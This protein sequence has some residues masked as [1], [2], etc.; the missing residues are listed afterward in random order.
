MPPKKV[1]SP[2]PVMNKALAGK[3]KNPKPN[4]VPPQTTAGGT[5]MPTTAEDRQLALGVDS[6]GGFAVPKQLGGAPKKKRRK[7]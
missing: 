4:K 7:K 5:K 2:R 6:A 1:T 3:Q